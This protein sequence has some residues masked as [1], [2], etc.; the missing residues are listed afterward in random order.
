MATAAMPTAALLE[1]GM[2]KLSMTN[3][4]GLTDRSTCSTTRSEY[5]RDPNRRV[6]GALTLE[7]EEALIGLMYDNFMAHES[8][9]LDYDRVVRCAVTIQCDPD[10][11]KALGAPVVTAEEAWIP[12]DAW[13][14]DMC[15]AFTDADSQLTSRSKPMGPITPGGITQLVTQG[16]VGLLPVPLPSAEGIPLG[17]TAPKGGSSTKKGSKKKGGKGLSD[18]ELLADPRAKPTGNRSASPKVGKKKGGKRPPSPGG[19]LVS[20]RSQSSSDK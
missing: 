15:F 16:A 9:S 18:A 2:A 1:E 12:D 11:C 14:T 19:R 7:Q 4:G 13:I 10:V 3:L 6:A 20:A 17:R 8:Q 5:G